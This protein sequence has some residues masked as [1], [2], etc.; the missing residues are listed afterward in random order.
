MK[1]LN[2]TLLSQKMKR[3]NTFSIF[4]LRFLMFTATVVAREG[5]LHGS[6]LPPERW[7]AAEGS[8][9]TRGGERHPVT[10]MLSTLGSSAG[11]RPAWLWT[12]SSSRWYHA[13][14]Q[15]L[16]CSS[17]RQFAGIFPQS[18]S[19]FS[20][21]LCRMMQNPHLWW[22]VSKHCQTG[23]MWTASDFCEV[24]F[25]NYLTYLNAHF[26]FLMGSSFILL[27]EAD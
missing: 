3:A 19:Y 7:C 23:F 18:L 8:S 21:N 6:Y 9:D 17:F 16:F 27:L 15:F 5:E 1:Q 25:Q 22:Y 20:W 12:L 24:C 14:E 10:F 13:L 26:L 4:F 2:I 11:R